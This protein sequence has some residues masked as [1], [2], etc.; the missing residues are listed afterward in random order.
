MR[1][2]ITA[3]RTAALLAIA[4]GV[5]TPPASAETPPAATGA[6]LVGGADPDTGPSHSYG[7]LGVGFTD[8]SAVGDIL[9][10]DGIDWD[11]AGADPAPHYSD[12]GTSADG[13]ASNSDS[14]TSNGMSAEEY[15]DHLEDNAEQWDEL[16]DQAADPADAARWRA[17]AAGLR[18][19]AARAPV[20]VSDSGAQTPPTG[21]PSDGE[22][23][24]S[25]PGVQADGSYVDVEE[26][27][28]GPADPT[29]VGDLPG[30][31]LGP[32]PDDGGYRAL[33][34]SAEILFGT[35]FE[36]RY[37][38]LGLGDEASDDRADTADPNSRSSHVEEETQP[39]DMSDTVL[40]AI[41]ELEAQTTMAEIRLAPSPGLPAVQPDLRRHGS[42]GQRNLE[43]AAPKVAA[44]DHRHQLHLEAGPS[45]SQ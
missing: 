24:T 39:A 44:L 36:A 28:L 41:R 30:N 5:A 9:S 40:D 38:S 25:T 35:F 16:A 26:G 10:G 8:S 1:A 22:A 11:E 17:H 18:A 19:E 42:L 3:L 4:V 15:A 7:D 34:L 21:A 13:A 14:E 45:R 2:S 31:Y 32:D 6:D 23:P 27:L 43:I 37:R 33:N 29:V 12:D 20:R